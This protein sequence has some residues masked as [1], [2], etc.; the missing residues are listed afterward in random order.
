MLRA[1]RVWC[2]STAPAQGLHRSLSSIQ[3]GLDRSIEFLVVFRHVL[4]GGV[5][6]VMAMTAVFNGLIQGPVLRTGRNT[7]TPRKIQ[8]QAP[9]LLVDA[10]ANLRTW[11][12]VI[13]RTQ[14]AP[15]WNH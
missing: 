1:G 15:A 13:A 6:P 12:Q 7:A 8:L 4:S 10:L 9:E 11:P 5:T 2:C 14:A 3:P